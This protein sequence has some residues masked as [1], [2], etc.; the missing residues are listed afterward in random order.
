MLVPQIP[1]HLPV[2]STSICISSRVNLENQRFPVALHCTHLT[3]LWE[4]PWLWQAQ[5]RSQQLPSSCS[6][7]SRPG[8]WQDICPGAAATPRAS[9]PHRHK[10]DTR[11]VPSLSPAAAAPSNQS[12]GATGGEKAAANL[13]QL[14]DTPT[15]FPCLHHSQSPPP[16][17]WLYCIL[18]NS[19]QEASTSPFFN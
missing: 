3:F 9:G 13:A 2:F 8:M 12:V 5:H 16:A 6:G 4:T 17:T 15:L 11:R 18:I 19:T 1:R 7:S 14:E 10:G